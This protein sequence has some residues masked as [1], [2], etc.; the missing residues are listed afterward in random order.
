[1]NK[2]LSSACVAVASLAV[3]GV[4]GAGAYYAI[5]KG[6]LAGNSADSTTSSADTTIHGDGADIRLPGGPSFL[7][8]AGSTLTLSA[9]LS[10]VPTVNVVVWTSLSSNVTL[11][12]STT[13]SGGTVTATLVNVFSGYVTVKAAWSLDS[14]VSASASLYCQNGVLHEGYTRGATGT[15]SDMTAAANNSNIIEAGDYD[16]IAPFKAYKSSSND[17]ASV[18]YTGAGNPITFCLNGA[19]LASVNYSSWGTDSDRLATVWEPLALT[20]SWKDISTHYQCKNLKSFADA[21][22]KWSVWARNY[23]NV[24]EFSL[25]LSGTLYD[26]DGS[27]INDTCSFEADLGP[28]FS[29]KFEKYVVAT[30]AGIGGGTVFN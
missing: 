3:V 16:S 20:S 8:E 22:G 29:C 4:A 17:Y 18:Q 1:M 6:N 27:E 26:V 7:S 2:F 23:S 13:V 5:N 12:A 21:T 28:T 10:P 15:S 9:T 19:F 25:R 14:N 24:A 30:S 11:S